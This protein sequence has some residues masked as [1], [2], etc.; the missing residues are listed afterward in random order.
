M[1]SGDSGPPGPPG[2]GA[3]L[4]RWLGL[5]LS[6]AGAAFVVRAIAV[7]WDEVGDAV[8]GLSAG[9]LLGALGCA[10]AG[11]TLIAARWRAS[12]RLAGGDLEPAETVA[13]YFRGE[14]AK[15]VPGGVWA[16]VGRAELAR[17]R[18]LPWRVAYASVTLSL[19][20]LY[21]GAAATAA[22]LAPFVLGFPAWGWAL[23]AVGGLGLAGLT[24]GGGAA[25]AVERSRLARRLPLPRPDRLARLMLG[26][27][28]AWL[29]VGTATWCAARALAPAAPFGRVLFA[30]ALAW[31]AGF[32]ALPAP[33]G[34]GVREAVFVAV[35]GPLAGGVT[36]AAAVLARLLF[37]VT[38]AVGA[39]VASAAP[40]WRPGPPSDAPDDERPGKGAE[41]L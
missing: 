31:L 19:V 16:V 32:L 14:I 23:W 10:A 18:G 1:A 8:A 6:V 13:V 29:L 40:R 34:I 37:M 35:A 38:D 33:G 7:R 11:M 2:P 24:L 26:Y 36:A 4:L 15:Y 17:R 39:L 25:R 30:T 28:P 41:H 3:R 12:V 21:A 22:V 5:A 9:W 20:A 27:V